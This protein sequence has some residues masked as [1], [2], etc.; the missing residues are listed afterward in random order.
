MHLLTA[1]RLRHFSFVRSYMC[2]F[3]AQR[4]CFEAT[5][6][7]VIQ[8]PSETECGQHADPTIDVPIA[9][10]TSSMYSCFIPQSFFIHFLPDTPQLQATDHS[11]L[12]DCLCFAHSSTFFIATIFQTFFTNFLSCLA[13]YSSLTPSHTLVPISYFWLLCKSPFFWLLLLNTFEWSPWSQ[14]PKCDVL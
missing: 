13:I 10:L 3:Y 1:V 14:W 2:L 5:A 7:W 8:C 4:I 9:T 6:L 12:G 11:N